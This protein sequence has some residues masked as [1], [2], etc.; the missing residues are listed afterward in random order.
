MVR[1][2][3]WIGARPLC[4]LANPLPGNA[5]WGMG[6]AQIDKSGVTGR[7]VHLLRRSMMAPL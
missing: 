7:L 6:S 1:S 5:P 2:V 3:R 4:Q